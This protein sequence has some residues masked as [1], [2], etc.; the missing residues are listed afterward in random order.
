MQLIPTG[1][2]DKP[3]D[4]FPPVY[5]GNR[6]IPEQDIAAELQHHPANELSEA[7]LEAARSLVI[8]EL[9]LQRAAALGLVNDDEERLIASLL[10]QELAVPEPTE[11]DCRRFYQ[12]RKHRFSRPTILAVSHILL[13]AAPD[14]ITGRMQ[15]EELGHRLLAQL[16]A[17]EASFQALA[18]QHSACESRHNGGNLGQLT[19][20][21]TVAEFEE[22]VWHFKEGLAPELVESRY[23]WHIVRVDRR[24]EGEP[25]PFEAAKPMVRHQLSES[26]TRR[27]LRHYIQILAQDVGVEGVALELPGS[28]LMQ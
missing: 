18:R 15:Q 1:D 2:A 17:G 6:L 16:R 4:R 20:G 11:D 24:L 21:Q 19:R 14:D 8:R 28:P 10:E 27:A 5:V 26:V 12:A 23:G 7:W 22:K 9:L 25:L 3:R 13:A